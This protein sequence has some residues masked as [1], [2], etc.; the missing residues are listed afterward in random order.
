MFL[1]YNIMQTK[2]LSSAVCLVFLL[3]VGMTFSVQAQNDKFVVV[4]DAG[5][6][7][8]DKGKP[9]KKGFHEKDIAL[10]IV[11]KV[12]KLLETQKDIKVVYTRKT[13]TF[14]DLFVRGKIANKVNAD[15]FVSV[16][17]NAAAS[18]QAYGSETFVL[19]VHRNKTNLNVAKAENAVIYLEDNHEEVYKGYDPNKPESLIGLTLAQEEYLDQSILLASLVQKQ[20][21]NQLKRKSRGVKQAGF[22]VLHQTV[23][24]S[25][26]VE[27]GFVTNPTEAKYLTSKNGQNKL[28]QSIA[29]AVSTYKKS[30][31]LR[32]N[33]NEL[34]INNTNTAPKEISVV[35]GVIFKV[36]LEAGKRKLAEKSYNF[37]GLKA[38]SRQ[39]VG[40]IYKY[41]AGHTSNYST[42]KS[43][44][45]KAISKG[46]KDAYVVAFK[47]GERV[48]L[49]EVLKTP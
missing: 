27:T 5:H 25:I 43:V 2:S 37:K 9:Y 44:K 15:L 30:I 36:Q 40:A 7:G 12:G 3:A 20:F 17:C 31:E 24:P 41:Y 8:K 11:L 49:S 39:K 47:D 21:K 48:N 14:V 28:A 34:P 33:T 6:G 42:I 13:D 26:L 45:Q 23:M 46:Y 32:L 4:L 38:I 22:I 19:G 16:H 1:P 29:K 18:K 35:S 10:S